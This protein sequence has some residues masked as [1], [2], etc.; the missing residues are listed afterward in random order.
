M[1]KHI[2]FFLVTSLIFNIYSQNTFEKQYNHPDYPLNGSGTL[3]I[4]DTSGYFLGGYS[5]VDGSMKSTI[6]KTD[7]KGEILWKQVV[8]NEYGT[9]RLINRFNPTEFIFLKSPSNL[10]TKSDIKVTNI[11]RAGTINWSETYVKQNWDEPDNII[12]TSD[13]GYL[14]MG[15][16]NSLPGIWEPH[17]Y[18][19][20]VLK[21]NEH[22]DTLWSGMIGGTT[23][24]EYAFDAVETIDSHYYVTGNDSQGSILLIKLDTNGKIHWIKKYKKDYQSQ[25][26]CISLTSDNCLLIAGTSTPKNTNQ[27]LFY[28]LKTDTDG[29][30]LWEKTYSA[31]GENYRPKLLVMESGF[32]IAG[33]NEED[34][35]ILVKA[36]NEGEIIWAK[37]L[38]TQTQGSV[39]AIDLCN[40]GGF[41]L[42]NHYCFTL[43]KTDSVG[44][45]KPK[46]IS[47]TGEQNVSL[48]EAITFTVSDVRGQVYNWSSN[49]GTVTSGQGTKHITMTWDETGTDTL[50]LVI[51]NECGKDSSLL[52]INIYDCVPLKVS[53]IRQ[54]GFFDFFIDKIEG[55]TPLYFWQ[56]DRGTI[57]SGQ[58]TNHIV[59]D[60]T[61]TG[62]L[63]VALNVSNECSEVND[64]LLFFYSQRNDTYEN[65]VQV[66]PNPTH[67]GTFQIT[68]IN[69]S[70]IDIQ[71]YNSLGQ[72]INSIK[73]EGAN[74]SQIDVRLH[75]QG[76]YVLK[77]VADKRVDTLKI[78]YQ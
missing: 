67:D 69:E 40:D 52:I 36:T 1:K 59:V 8:S 68:N 15:H 13:K 24:N 55:K 22:G 48:H 4:A 43:I 56:V 34:K 11:N 61:S 58:Y 3:A 21:L 38:P 76:M 42:T 20:F 47:V 75:E 7:W 44:C 9:A 5:I 72:L 45:V 10:T 27:S 41:L 63:K 31:G 29:N 65:R 57:L 18:D 12:Q 35:I 39:S 78:L 64:S 49:R 25:P 77:I 2:V 32:L 73:P 66:F 6:L 14:V 60:W 50:K 51:E 46:L 53:P 19:A 74:T 26:N 33:N 54:E 62:E 30:L 71:V 17:P 23:I 37:T 28:A 16:S 70:A